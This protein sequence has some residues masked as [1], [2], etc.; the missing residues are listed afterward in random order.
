M[1]GGKT[2]HSTFKIPLDISNDSLCNVSRSSDL[3]KLFQRT[4]VIIW[5]EAP[6]SHKYNIEAVDRMLK[7]IC[8]NDEDFGGKIVV[9]SG[10]FRQVLPVIKRGNRSQ[11]VMAS[12]KKSILWRKIKTLK[13]IQNVR[14]FGGDQSDNWKQFLLN[15]G[16][17]KNGLLENVPI[18][19]NNIM[20]SLDSLID[21]ITTTNTEN[22]HDSV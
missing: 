19:N 16:E 15:V 7:D 20:P 8:Q 11:T 13:L 17:G 9:F 3:A 22:E 6:M 21:F 14:V 4:D 18:S 2:S 12:L 5:D 1:Q 10:D